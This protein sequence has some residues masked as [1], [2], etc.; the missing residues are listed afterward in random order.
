MMLYSVISWSLT[1]ILGVWSLILLSGHGAASIAGFNTMTEDEKKT[2]DEKKLCFV[3]GICMLISALVLFFMAML[4]SKNITNTTAII[5]GS[6]IAIDA[7]VMVYIANTKCK[8]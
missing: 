7:A 6:I 5:A 3:A 8:K 4:G 1:A 2:I